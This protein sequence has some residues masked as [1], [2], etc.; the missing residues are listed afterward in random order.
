VVR[1]FRHKG[2]SEFF[3]TGRTKHI[4]RALHARVARVLN[5]LNAA[6]C[7]TDLALPGFNCHPLHGDR[8][9]R[10]A[11]NVGQPWRITFRFAEGDAHEVDLEQYH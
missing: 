3:N 5:A 8:A 4:N 11:I 10:H 6:T 1:N 2:L 9:G 7:L